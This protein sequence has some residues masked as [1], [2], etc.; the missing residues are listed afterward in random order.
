MILVA[1]LILA[2]YAGWGETIA[3]K[4]L[5]PLKVAP[6]LIHRS[7]PLIDAIVVVLC[8]L[9]L[10]RTYQ[11][12]KIRC[13]PS[14]FIYCFK[15][16]EK[17]NLSG[18]S[19]VVG[20][21]HIKPD[22]ESGEIRATGASF[23]WDG[24][25]L[26]ERTGFTSTLVRGAQNNNETICHIM[27]DIDEDDQKKRTYS[28]G[29][30]QFQLI[31]CAA[32]NKD[33]DAYVGYLKSYTK[34]L[35]LQD[36][37]VRA[38]GYA[39]WHSKGCVPERAIKPILEESGELLFAKFTTV[40]NAMPPPVLWISSEP[41]DNRNIWKQDIPTPQSVILNDELRPFVERY[42][43][44]VLTLLGLN[45][46]AVKTFQSLA[47]RRARK[48]PDDLLAYEREL[49]AGLIGQIVRREEDK[50]LT[51]RAEIIYDEIKGFFVGDSLLDIGCGNGLISNLAR[52][53]FKR[54]Q[55]LDVVE[56]VPKGLKLAFTSYTEGYPLPIEESFDTVFLLT[57]L[58]HSAKPVELLQLAWKATAHRLIII[59]SVVGIDEIKPPVR[60]DLVGRPIEDQIAYAAFIDWFYNRV[61]HDDVPV[62][63]NFTTPQE[64]EAIFLKKG[65]RLKR[66]IHFGQDIEIGPEYHVLFVVDK[67]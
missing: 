56:Y 22:V 65:M 57:V 19:H 4:L 28:H 64:W 16:P 45:D 18:K 46:V 53:D 40:L 11:R 29:V 27:F 67:E 63:Y 3:T 30:L 58:H 37:V 50:A 44:T 47:I 39:E 42:L 49:K 48:E 23:F 24:A 59:E 1:T 9:V 2:L 54:I 15:L 51:Q 20:Y 61:L 32:D 10:I 14:T 62:P 38:R 60:Y 8:C 66:T 33:K 26:S 36:V 55:L 52:A 13:Y 17:S 21:C 12:L 41:P 5:E 31:G 25:L 43:D 6:D 35:E 7:W 34:E